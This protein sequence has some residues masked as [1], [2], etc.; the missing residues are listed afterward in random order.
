MTALDPQAAWRLAAWL[1]T[2]ASF[3]DRVE[4]LEDVEGA[5]PLIEPAT[6]FA[7]TYLRNAE[8]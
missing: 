7:C 2:T 5:A 6:R 4:E 3:E 8:T 1:E